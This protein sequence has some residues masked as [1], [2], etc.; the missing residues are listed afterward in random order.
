MMQPNP[1]SSSE[2]SLLNND[3]LMKLTNLNPYDEIGASSWLVRI[4]PFRLL[5]DAGL[6]PKHMG[7]AALPDYSL[8]DDNSLD[9]IILTHCHLDHLGSLPV[10]LRRQLYTDVIMSLPS[11]Q[12]A[13]RMLRNSVNVMMR[14]REEHDILEYPLFTFRELNDVEQRFSPMRYDRTRVLEK[15]GEELELTLYE[16]GHVPGACGVL[17]KYKH[18]EI[19]F[20]GDCL[21]RDQHTLAGADFPQ[22]PF[23]T[24]VLETTRGATETEVAHDR[25]DEIQR[26]LETID[27]TLRHGGSVLIPVFALGR[28]QEVIAI[29]HAARL[30]GDLQECPIFCSGLGMALVDS[31]DGIARKTGYV[32]FR[33]K[34]LKDLKIKQLATDLRPGEDPQPNGIYIL[35]SGMMVEHTPSYRC[36]AAM[37][38][39]RENSICFV[40][41]CDPD[42]PGGKVLAS[43]PG[44]IVYFDA[45]HY[46]AKRNARVY[47]FDLSGHAD[48]EQLLDFATRADPRALVLTH[49]DPDSRAWFMDNIYDNPITASIQVFDPAPKETIE[50]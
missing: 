27:E 24:L 50:V 21:F 28:M 19:F 16:A 46:N 43:E 29:L 12:L 40:G 34:M 32:N 47:R 2:G 37:M 9:F 44:D 18:R 49:G 31:F 11:Q 26:L 10:I 6:N 36:A 42:T 4:G 17:L 7:Y 39:H 25:K 23:D 48:R 41:Y 15:E 45:L 5:I 22:G 13:T 20:T 1:E 14:Q 38:E 30:R 3:I 8:V 35:S 33:A